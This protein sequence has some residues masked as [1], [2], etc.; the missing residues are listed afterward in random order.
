MELITL[1]TVWIIAQPQ[2]N[3]EGLENWVKSNGFEGL[4]DS[5]TP[6]REIFTSDGEDAERLVEFAGRHCYRAWRKGR[7]RSD[8]IANI[9]ESNHGSV[10]EHAYFSFAIQGVSRSLSLEHNRHRV[11]IAISQE[12]QRYVDASEINAVVP[13]LLLH[14]GASLDSFRQMFIA[15]V[16]AYKAEQE[17]LKNL[18]FNGSKTEMRKRANEAARCHLPNA[19]E[20]RMVWTANVRTLRH[21]FTM[22]GSVHADLEIRRLATLMLHSVKKR[23]PYFFYDMEIVPGDFGVPNISVNGD[24]GIR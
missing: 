16:D 15:Q 6:L 21:Y 23:Y 14:T 4:L 5:G 20:T 2:I 10:L 3:L 11:G 24:Q 19:S 7:E 18:V 12:S 22:R 9:I 1:P 8:Y 17:L 13:P